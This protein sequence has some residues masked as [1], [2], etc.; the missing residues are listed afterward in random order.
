MK[1]REMTALST[2]EQSILLVEMPFFFFFIQAAKEL[3]NS[4]EKTT[5]VAWSFTVTLLG[6][7]VL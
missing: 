5:F 4:V 3:K 1:E 6:D 2:E 7:V